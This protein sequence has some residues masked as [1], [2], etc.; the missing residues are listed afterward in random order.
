MRE[1]RLD[2]PKRGNVSA[3]R[4]LQFVAG[5]AELAVWVGEPGFGGG[6][7][8]LHVRSLATGAAVTLDDELWD[9]MEPVLSPD[10]RFLVFENHYHGSHTYVEDLTRRSE[11]GFY[12]PAIPGAPLGLGEVVFAPD[13]SEL[14]AV[15]HLSQL[16]GQQFT[17]DLARFPLEPYRNPPFR[18]EQKLNPL[19]NRVM[20]VALYDEEWQATMVWHDGVPLPSG[21]YA[22]SAAVSAD[23]QFVA[24]GDDA[25]SVLVVE[26]ARGE[27]TAS[28]RRA[29]PVTVSRTARAA[30]RI[31]F[32]PGAEWV[33]SLANGR[34][35]ADPFGPGKAWKT[36]P[37]QVPVNDFAVHPTGRFVC[38]VG[39]DGR[40]RYLDPHTGSVMQTFK[41]TRGKQQLHSVSIAP[42]GLTCAAGGEK[43]RVVLWDVDG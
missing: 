1:L 18:Y 43:G 5:G 20:R 35:F 24:V 40:A 38:A 7:I 26:L 6:T 3:V 28:F 32:V 41:W 4:R 10:G 9:G 21:W 14:L 31:A 11:D 37:K 39:A 34:L 17:R 33:V 22:H 16:R 42:D 30:H 29:W 27:V 12:L 23:G 2:V 25:G 19:N 13:G 15:R 8:A 36:D